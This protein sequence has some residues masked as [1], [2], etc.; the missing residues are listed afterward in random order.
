M[1]IISCDGPRTTSTQYPVH[2][3]EPVSNNEECPLI[4]THEHCV[5]ANGAAAKIRDSGTRSDDGGTRSDP[6]ARGCSFGRGFRGS[7][8][9]SLHC[10]WSWQF[11]RGWLWNYRKSVN[12]LFEQEL[13]QNLLANDHRK[14]TCTPSFFLMAEQRLSYLTRTQKRRDGRKKVWGWGEKTRK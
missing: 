7:F 9:R 12:Q 10:S 1:P 6:R 5:I 4:W 3:P 14:T 8:S 2:E 13:L 11:S